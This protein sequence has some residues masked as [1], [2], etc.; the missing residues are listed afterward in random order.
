MSKIK[1]VLNEAE[2]E[3]KGKS[4]MLPKLHTLDDSIE[5]FIQE[6]EN[7]ING[8]KDNPIFQRNAHQLL[9]DMSKE[10]SEFIF[11]LRAIVN[12]VDRKGQVLPK[13]KPI[14]RI[15]DV[16]SKIKPPDEEGGVVP[17][18]GSESEDGVPPKGVKEALIMDKV[19]IMKR[20]ERIKEL[21][22]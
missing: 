7:K 6:L 8:V 15:R 21:L 14:G 5:A 19:K 10:Y 2:K 11:A 18:E 22:Q 1:T 17:P 16:N 12:A 9:G 13:E 20:N 3:K 4:K